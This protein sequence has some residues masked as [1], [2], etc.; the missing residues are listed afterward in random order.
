MQN[1]RTLNSV[2]TSDKSSVHEVDAFMM[3]AG[4]HESG[5]GD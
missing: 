4:E 3:F 1:A 2:E 5:S